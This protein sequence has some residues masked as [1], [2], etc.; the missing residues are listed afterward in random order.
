MNRNT[1]FPVLVLIVLVILC[2]IYGPSTVW[3]FVNHPIFWIVA[4]ALLG[5]YLLGSSLAM[6]VFGKATK[7][8]LKSHAEASQVAAEEIQQRDR[9]VEQAA[10]VL[11]DQRGSDSGPLRHQ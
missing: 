11:G 5:I 8:V 4:V 7:R 6:L 3:N 1:S 2:V 10:Q 9:R